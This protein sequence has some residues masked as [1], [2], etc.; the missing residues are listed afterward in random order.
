MYIVTFYS[1]FRALPGSRTPRGIDPPLLLAIAKVLN[2]KVNF[3]HMNWGWFDK[4][5]VWD[6]QVGLVGDIS[7]YMKAFVNTPMAFTFYPGINLHI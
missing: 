3:T 5:G 2:F 4:D 6:G 7:N 1:I